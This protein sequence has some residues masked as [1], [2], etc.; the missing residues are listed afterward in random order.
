MDK[1]DSANALSP[2]FFIGFCSGTAVWMDPTADSHTP[3]LQSLTASR[4]HSPVLSSPVDLRQAESVTICRRMRVCGF[5]ILPVELT[6]HALP[7]LIH[8]FSHQFLAGRVEVD[9]VKRQIRRQF[10][11][12]SDLAAEIDMDL[13]PDPGIDRGKPFFP[14]LRRRFVKGPAAGGCWPD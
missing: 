11:V 5:V 4:H 2:L 6:D 8:R 10:L 3:Q 1:G 14:V 13:G 7:L 9:A 12:F